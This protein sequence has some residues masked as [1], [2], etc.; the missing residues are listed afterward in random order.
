MFSSY[1]RKLSKSIT[2]NNIGKMLFLLMILLLNF[3]K[4]I[5][6]G[7]VPF[8]FAI[9][10][11][12]IPFIILFMLI[13]MKL[14][15][16]A[17]GVKIYIWALILF[18]WI[19]IVGFHAISSGTIIDEGWKGLLGE[20]IK[21]FI[22]LSYFYIG[23][24]ALLIIK[25]KYI[26]VIWTISSYLFMIIG[27]LL[28]FIAVNNY[29]SNYMNLDKYKFFFMGTYTDPNHAAT[30]LG[31]NAFLMMRFARRENRIGY[32]WVYYLNTIISLGL[33]LLTDSRGGFLAA[34]LASIV[35]IA[36]RS[37]KRVIVLLDAI[38]VFWMGLLAILNI[39]GLIFRHE[40]LTKLYNSFLNFG[41]G[42]DTRHSLAL[43]A[44]L[45]GKDNP[46]FG[47]GR[48]N[49]IVNSKIYF[50]FLNLEYIG[51]IPH[52]TYLGLFSETGIIG[53]LL[54]FFPLY[55]LLYVIIK[56]RSK[57][58]DN[59]SNFVYLN[60]ELLA[61]LCVVM[62]QASVLNIENQR[63]L[64]F[65][66]GMAIYYFKSFSS[67]KI[68]DPLKVKLD[69][70][71]FLKRG[72]SIIVLIILTL[73]CSSN[74]YILK[75]DTKIDG[76]SE[77]ELD[78]SDFGSDSDLKV[79]YNILNNNEDSIVVMKL[80]E[81]TIYGNIIEHAHYDY[82]NVSGR[83]YVNFKRQFPDSKVFISFES[84]KP[85]HATF[86]VKLTSLS[87]LE[88]IKYIDRI[89]PL[90]F[91]NESK[92]PL[93]SVNNQADDLETF[94]YKELD[95]GFVL[96]GADY[97]EN[98]TLIIKIKAISNIDKNYRLSAYLLPTSISRFKSNGGVGNTENITLEHIENTTMWNV[99]EIHDLHFNVSN[100]KGDYI[101]YFISSYTDE[102]GIVHWLKLKNTDKSDIEIG[103]IVVE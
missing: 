44:W 24:K 63:V 103:K 100:I 20:L 77:T 26:K 85:K 25:T 13:N 76:K 96:V 43:V 86:N 21:L 31:I 95:N 42:Y 69:L 99:N 55:L 73:L 74:V 56:N 8:N 15:D 51:K 70:Y 18:F 39:D 14:K 82:D 35:W 11:F 66:S 101:I 58:A 91:L 30:F 46:I 1:Y 65:L 83:D 3:M 10:D 71:A 36:C 90:R 19:I 89:Y 6:I 98:K 47:V 45:I 78:L 48:G 27:L 7:Q 87:T 12:V 102:N 17:E 38:L 22:N 68:V 72:V 32:R 64:W 49:Y 92:Y 93:E 79:S 54:Y 84:I 41:S 61:I 80:T 81:I 53:I 9:S 2:L 34:F 28:N 52:N 57:I 5:Y 88:K 50:D 29:F 59:F 16:I 37:T 67:F 60:S 4:V 62:V 33:I 97:K 23:Y 40:F 94:D 75:S